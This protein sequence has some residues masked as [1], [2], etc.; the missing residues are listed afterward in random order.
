MLL[1]LL[2]VV[3]VIVCLLLQDVR[4]V[5]M[6]LLRGVGFYV[7]SDPNSLLIFLDF[8]SSQ[9]TTDAVDQAALVAIW[10]GLTNKGTLGWNTTSSLCGQNKVQCTS[11]GKV[12]A[13]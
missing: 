13:L 2:L 12:N 9:N 4:F 8:N 5:M 6:S 11:A 1:Q 3:M 7:V 10:K